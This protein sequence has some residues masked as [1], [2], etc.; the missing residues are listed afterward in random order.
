MGQL[1]F[2]ME[3]FTRE[4]NDKANRSEVED[5]MEEMKRYTK[6]GE[7]EELCKRVDEKAEWTDHHQLKAKFEDTVKRIE[8]FEN[9]LNDLKIFKNATTE[10]IA[11]MPDN[12]KFDEEVQAIRD[13]INEMAQAREEKEDAS[14]Q[15]MNSI[16]TSLTKF[17]QK[18]TRVHRD[19]D[20]KL[21]RDDENRIMVQVKRLPQY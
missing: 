12:E 14:D 7:F 4:F 9:V 5:V 8:V 19:M 11:N 21:G 16:E 18:L 20:N 2:E 3:N 15:R 1:K 17:Q 13:R 6:Y 10:N